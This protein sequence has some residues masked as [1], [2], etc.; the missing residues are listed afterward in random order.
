MYSQYLKAFRR[1][2]CA[3]CT[4]WVELRRVRTRHNSLKYTHTHTQ[5]P[6]PAVLDLLSKRRPCSIPHS[7]RFSFH[8]SA[9]VNT[10]T[11]PSWV[12]LLTK[13]TL[14]TR[15]VS[16]IKRSVRFDRFTLCC[17]LLQSSLRKRKCAR[18]KLKFQKIQK[19]LP[20]FVRQQ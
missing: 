14:Q 13:P 10:H 4:T 5:S 20:T 15:P 2:F 6:L 1:S 9:A 3:H 19:V 18:G 7:V 12:A 11:D 17:V 8:V 16:Q